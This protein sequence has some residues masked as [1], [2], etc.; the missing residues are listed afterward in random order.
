MERRHSSRRMRAVSL[1]KQKTHEAPQDDDESMIAEWGLTKAQEVRRRK[2]A[3]LA[4][5]W[6]TLDARALSAAYAGRRMCAAATL[7]GKQCLLLPGQHRRHGPREAL[8]CKHERR[9]ARAPRPCT[10]VSDSL[11]IL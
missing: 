2:P 1:R 9:A 10:D 8:P 7:L 5:R 3:C 4:C 6:G 11:A